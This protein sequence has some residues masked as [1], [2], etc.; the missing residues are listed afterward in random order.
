MLKFFTFAYKNLWSRINQTFLNFFH[1]CGTLY[2]YHFNWF[3]YFYLS[4]FEIETIYNSLDAI[5]NRGFILS[6]SINP[7]SSFTIKMHFFTVNLLFDI[8]GIAVAL[9]VIL[10]TYFKWSY[11]YW[12]RKGVPYIQPSIPFGNVDNILTR[13]RNF[14]TIVKDLY[15]ELKTRNAKF[16]GFYMFTAPFFIPI[17]P[18]VIKCILVKDFG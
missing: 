8:F 18:E 14:G 6:D 12:E 13:K 2:L 11:K 17:D 9:S 15:N 16:G 1:Y 4:F 5:Y 3:L 7:H 10:Y